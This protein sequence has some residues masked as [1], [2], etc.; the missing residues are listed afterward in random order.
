MKKPS[1]AP[2]VNYKRRLMKSKSNWLLALHATNNN[3]Q[4]GEDGDLVVLPRMDCKTMLC[5]NRL[6]HNTK[7]VY[8]MGETASLTPTWVALPEK[9]PPGLHNFNFNAGVFWPPM[10]RRLQMM[11]TQP[12][13]R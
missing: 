3:K 5:S 1:I 4:T 7:N 13:Q 12:L 10:M 8:P 11:M 9:G 6:R 2:F